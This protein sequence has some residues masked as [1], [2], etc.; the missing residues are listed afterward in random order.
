LIAAIERLTGLEWKGQGTVFLV[1]S[2]HGGTHW[3]A[4]TFYLLLPFITRDL[5]LTYAEAGTLVAVFHLSA[6]AANF[7]SGLA[8]DVTG[9]RVVYQVLSLFIG[10]G[11]LLGCGVAGSV[12]WLF[13]MVVLIGAT[14]NL[15]HPPAISFLSEHYPKQRGYALSIHALGANVGDAMAPLAAGALLVWLSW[16]GTASVS[17]LPVFALAAWIAVSLTAKDSQGQRR[18]AA[19]SGLGEYWQGVKGLV[20]NRL[21]LHL[22]LLAGFRT[23]AQMGLLV[24]L[25]LYLADVAGMGPFMM[26]VTVMALQVGG[27]FA[28]PIAGAWSDRIGRR[29]V[30]LGG[31]SASTVLIVVLTLIQND[32]VFIAGV[33][34]LGFV[35]YAARPVIHSWM[36]DLAPTQV[37]ASATS[38]MFGVQAMF[39]A[40]MVSGG[41][42]VADKW[43]L[44]MVFY[45]LAA[46][47][48][49]ANVLV[50]F[51]PHHKPGQ[52][53]PDG[54][55]G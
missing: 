8:V 22:S 40:V 45:L 48:L 27:I 29:P 15:W 51:M 28:S 10:A 42:V 11:A 2:G 34:V 6:F 46:S 50:Y 33:S 49:I 24:F 26:G 32:V 4:A 41:G 37:A 7:G 9:R 12:L 38:V 39:V 31:L 43:G 1:A 3:I 44:S 18:D 36:M 5:G 53:G 14:N 23:M 35:M 20:R 54:R 19:V 55:I 25:P 13:P 21:I 17:A 52:D 16:R 47:M 30:V